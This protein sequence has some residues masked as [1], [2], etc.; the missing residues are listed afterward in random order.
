MSESILLKTDP[1]RYTLGVVY[2]PRA[3]DAHDDWADAET[4]RVAAWDFTRKLQGRLPILK[5]ALA[6]IDAVTHPVSGETRI[7]I[8]DLLDS[9]VEKGRVGDMHAQWDDA[10]GDV[11]ESYLAPCDMLINGEAVKAGTW[12]LGVVWSEEM[13]AKILKGERIGYSLGGLAQR[14]DHA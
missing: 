12:L 3:V 6:V 2:E 7:D 4:I 14:R 1:L 8:T 10:L 13:F 9:V 11:V 5:T